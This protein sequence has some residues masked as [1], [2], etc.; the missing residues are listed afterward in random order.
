MSNRILAAVAAIPLIWATSALAQSQPSNEPA[1]GMHHEMRDPVAWHK[2][3][4]ANHYAHM[5]GRLAF[6][7]AR[8]N[9]TDAQKAAWD[10]WRQGRLDVAAKMRDACVAAVPAQPGARPTILDREAQAEKMMSARL[11]GLQA[12]RPALEA[13]YAVLTPD[14]KAVLD[15]MATDHPGGWHHRHDGMMREGPGGG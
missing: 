5:A 15:R 8:L 6:V 2:E 9:L 7:E 10:A 1:P 12:S 4:C 14:Q 13:L 3:K 11:A